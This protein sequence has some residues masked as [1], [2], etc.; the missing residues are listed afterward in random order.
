MTSGVDIQDQDNE[1]EDEDLQPSAKSCPHC[2]YEYDNN[3]SGSMAYAN[4]VRIVH[5]DQTKKARSGGRKGGS[6]EKRPSS[7]SQ[8]PRPAPVDEEYLGELSPMAQRFYEATT[9]VVPNNKAN[10]VKQMVTMFQRYSQTLA[11]DRHRFRSWIIRYGLTPD[12]VNLVEDE[13]FGIED[14]LGTPSAQGGMTPQ[15]V[16]NPGGGYQQ[17]WYGSQP[18]GHGGDRP[19]NVNVPP[20]PVPP[21]QTDSLR[22]EMREMRYEMGSMLKDFAAQVVQAQQQT[23]PVPSV[24]PMRRIPIMNDEGN[25]LKDAS[26]ETV[27]Q[28]VPVDE[29]SSMMDMF[30]MA[31]DYA[32]PVVG[33]P[34]PPPV[35]EEKLMMKMR[36][37]IRESTPEPEPKVPDAIQQSVDEMRATTINLQQ[38][39]SGLERER[40]ITSAVENAVAPL[41]DRLNDLQASSGL[42]DHQYELAHKERMAGG[43]RDMVSGVVDGVREDV[44]PMVVQSM[45]SN[46][47]NAGVPDEV[48]AGVL[49]NSAAT[50]PTRSSALKDRINEAK[51]QWLKP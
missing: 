15:M 44:K 31:L 42:T 22:D 48:I 47:K 2:D 39:L 6:A 45:A 1:N 50:T 32:K 11:G 21:P 12:Q 35:D 10:L 13:M 3:S 37:E 16:P 33:A 25:I 38:Q 41:A 24:H 34:P 46:L 8:A 19:I 36:E 29:S 14:L 27:F 49:Q 40:D 17:V 4:H 43:W 5:P 28:E 23:P 18:G 51:A 26:G 20:A 7:A 30:K 9:Q